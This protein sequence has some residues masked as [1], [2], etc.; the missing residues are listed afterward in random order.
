[1]RHGKKIKKLGRTSA[2]RKATLAALSNALI[3]HKR[4]T[5]T[6]VKAKALRGFVEPLI[7][8]AKADTVH[9][10]RQV[11]RRLQDKESVTRLFGEVAEKI[12]DRP[13]GY[14]R[15]VKL[16]RRQGDGA[17][18]A[19]IEIVDYNDVKPDGAS[20]SSK[21]KTR[22]G[23]RRTA[24][25][26]TVEATPAPVAEVV[27]AVIEGEV[28]ETEAETEDVAVEE[29]AATVDSTQETDESDSD[30]TPD[31]SDQSGKDP[32]AN[33]EPVSAAD[34]SDDNDEDDAEG[35]ES[36]VEKK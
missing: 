14:T 17:E 13:G 4:I 27:E 7:N 20:G 10:R 8:R 36:E 5:T 15:V 2:H 22:R 24:T 32:I 31:V 30:A 34:E 28:V 19:M 1:M 23:R 3:E 6:Y 9:N 21:R 25:A 35:A 29:T 33:P 26:T 18:V 12:G 11:F 16:G